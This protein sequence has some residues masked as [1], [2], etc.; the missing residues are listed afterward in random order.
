[1]E[2][3]PDLLSAASHID[4]TSLSLELRDLDG[5]SDFCCANR[6][7]PKSLQ[8]EDDTE[9]RRFF[10]FLALLLA[11]VNFRQPCLSQQTTQASPP[12]SSADPAVLPDAPSQAQQNPVPPTVPTTPKYVYDGKQTKRILGIIPNFRSVSVDEKLPPL[13]PHDKF[14]LTFEDTF[15]YSNFIYVGILSG[16][17]Q[18]EGSYPEFHTGPPAYLRYYW[19]SFADTLD[20]N[21]M[22][23]FLLPTAIREDPRYYTLG[24]GGFFKRAGY[25][26]GR[27]LV[28]RKDS[29]GPSPNFSE[30]IGN[31]A[32]AGISGLYYPSQER[33]WTKTGQRWVTQIGLDGFANLIKEFW[34]D[35][36][37]KILHRQY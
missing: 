23:E 32:A 1:M 10:L 11:V 17:S 5:G 20:G 14:K 36:N 8:M 18:A 26:V 31:G 19:H 37:A 9:M 13:S 4:S 29:G 22:T 12:S 15:D 6:S 21:L 35:V 30:I 24:R 2:T 33:T 34:P 27:L 25:S 3:A 28:T 16:I 7:F